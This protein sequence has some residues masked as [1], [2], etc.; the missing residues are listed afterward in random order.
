MSFVL[1]PLFRIVIIMCSYSIYQRKGFLKR[2]SMAIVAMFVTSSS[3]RSGSDL[4]ADFSSAGAPCR[5]L[6]RI[7]VAKGT[8]VRKA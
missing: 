1:I 2:T 7:R 4:K 8:I 5:A 6:K 3:S